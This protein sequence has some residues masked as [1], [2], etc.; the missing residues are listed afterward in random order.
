MIN[1]LWRGLFKC[2]VLS[3]C[4]VGPRAKDEYVFVDVEEYI[5]RFQL[6]LIDRVRVVGNR[7]GACA[8][9]QL[10]GHRHIPAAVSS[11]AVVVGLLTVWYGRV[12]PSNRVRNHID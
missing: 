12:E 1:S 3:L 9:A 4:R 10:P 6:R 2:P 5:T 7:P 8:P 11:V